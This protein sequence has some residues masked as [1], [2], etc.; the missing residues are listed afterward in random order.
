M[1]AGDM[2]NPQKNFEYTLIVYSI[3]LH[4][5]KQAFTQAQM[6]IDLEKQAE[7]EAMDN[8]AIEREIELLK[9]DLKVDQFRKE[10]KEA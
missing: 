9:Q 8:R 5:L 6:Q 1:L 10:G 2:A 7:K 3:V 4:R